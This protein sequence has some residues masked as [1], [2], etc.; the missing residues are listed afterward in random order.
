MASWP[1]S[2]NASL[3][4]PAF[5][6]ATKTLIF[7]LVTFIII[8]TCNRLFISS[9]YSSYVNLGT[10]LALEFGFAKASLAW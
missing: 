4:M 3:T 2:R 10:E 7:T 1:A 5:S 8:P 6:Q 9:P